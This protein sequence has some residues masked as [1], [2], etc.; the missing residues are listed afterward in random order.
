MRRG[1]TAS[2]VGSGSPSRN[3]GVCAY[4]G[5]FA[6][7]AR[8]ASAAPAA[9][10]PTTLATASMRSHQSADQS[11]SYWSSSRATR[12]SRRTFATRASSA[13]GLRLS[14]HRRPEPARALREHDRHQ[15]GR[16]VG[17]SVARRATGQT[18]SNAPARLGSSTADTLAAHGVAPGRVVSLLPSL[19][20]IVCALGAADGWS[21]RSHECDYPPAVAR[22]PVL[23]APRFA[24][25]AAALE[26]HD[27]RARAR[28]GARR[29]LVLPRGRRRLRA[30]APDLILTQDQCRVCA[31]SLADVERALAAWLGRRAARGL[32]GAALARRGF[33]ACGAWRRRSALA[34]EGEAL[35]RALTAR[36]SAI[37]ERAGGSRRARAWRDR[38]ARPADGRRPLAA[39]AGRD[40]WRRAAARERGHAL[41]AGSRGSSWR[42]RS[43]RDRGAAVR[44]PAR[45]HAPRARPAARAARLARAPR[46]P[47][48]AACSSPT[49]TSTSTARGRGWSSRSRS[50]PRS[51]PRSASRS[52]R[53]PWLGAAVISAARGEP[54]RVE[55]R[56][57]PALAE[58]AVGDEPRGER[59]EQHAV[60]VVPGRHHQARARRATGRRA[61]GGRA[62]PA[63]ARPTPR[64]SARRPP[65]AAAPRPRAAGVATPPAV[66]RRSKPT[67]STV[68]PTTSEPSRFGTR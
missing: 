1:S 53:G 10:S 36:I 12:G 16:A 22:L 38:V 60:A 34:A 44:L 23:T 51:W 67:R 14:I 58:H 64:E 62:C 47:G 33:G 66:T 59:R 19:T 48:R 56:L 39:R 9:S 4:C 30:L 29:A 21:G 3:S 63:A 41:R 5:Y 57:V 35:L 25:E 43:G 24:S 15:R 8:A 50:S 40:R 20:E 32:G 45:A 17:A 18:S 13:P 37:G 52:A 31:A 7:S 26:R 11:A 49:G 6:R 68:A 42:R 28:A 46:G 61:A 54:C 2:R 65:R 27:R 55:G